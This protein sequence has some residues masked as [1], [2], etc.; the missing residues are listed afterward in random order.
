TTTN[1]AMDTLR[2]EGDQALQF[3]ASDTTK[4]WIASSE[5]IFQQNA[6]LVLSS[7]QN[8][9]TSLMHV[10][11]AAAPFLH[12][13]VIG[14][15]HMTAGWERSTDDVGRLR[16]RIRPLVD[17]TKAWW[18]L[19]DA[20]FHLLSDL[21]HAGAPA[22]TS[23]VEDFTR[24]LDRWDSWVKANP[25]KVRAF[26]H[27]TVESTEK[28]ASAIGGI[29]HTL[30]EAATLLRPFL[31]DLAG[32]STLASTLGL[33]GQGGLYAGLLGARRGFGGGAAGSRAGPGGG[34]GG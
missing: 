11:E 2:R 29:V 16:D 13:A 10:S 21:F 25:E 6:G 31:N 15:E 5:A 26:F 19:T 20:T 3:I 24:T 14:L 28:I 7:A 23:M 4:T 12:E 27:D 33:S 8:V 17:D 1:A 34:G 9:A 32:L 30:N 18:R 22:G